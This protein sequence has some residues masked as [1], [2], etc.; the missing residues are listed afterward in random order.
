MIRVDHPTFRD[1]SRQV[2][3][4]SVADW[5]Q[6]GWVPHEKPARSR[7]TTPTPDPATSGDP[8]STGDNA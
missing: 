8:S 3:D 1:V 7:R 5:V 2:P 6:Q 4:E